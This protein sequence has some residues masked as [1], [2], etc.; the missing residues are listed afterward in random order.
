MNQ[1]NEPNNS[2]AAILDYS[3][4]DDDIYIGT[5]KCC[6]KEFAPELKKKGIEAVVSLEETRVDEPFGVQFYIWLPVKDHYAPTLEQIEFGAN[7]IEQLVSLGKKVYVHCLNGHGRAPTL[8][9]AYFV[10]KGM[11]VDAAIELIKSKRPSV[12]PN[13]LQIKALREYISGIDAS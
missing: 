8:V 2:E 6:Q 9:A 10:K 5:N 11:D 4:I 13:D 7:A 12:H 1:Q 3:Y